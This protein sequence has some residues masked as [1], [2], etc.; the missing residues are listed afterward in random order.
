MAL[1][2]ET[3]RTKNIGLI[4][5]RMRTVMSIVIILV[6]MSNDHVTKP[7]AT[8]FDEMHPVWKLVWIGVGL[9]CAVFWLSV[10][11]SVL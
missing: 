9:L 4:A 11:M 7:D 5:Q 8:A 10:L 3:T 6:H 1:G 2:P